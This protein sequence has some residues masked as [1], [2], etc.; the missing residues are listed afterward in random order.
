MLI[1]R[2]TTSA[3]YNTPTIDSIMTGAR[4][5]HIQP[6]FRRNGRQMESTPTGSASSSPSH[7]SQGLRR[8]TNSAA[9]RPGEGTG[10]GSASSEPTVTANA[11]PD[12][13]GVARCPSA[14]SPR[15]LA[16]VTRRHT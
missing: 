16:T 3:M 4:A 14:R 1:R 2:D 7:V 12:L 9:P 10:F 8:T 13:G 11:W 6:R 15:S 5:P